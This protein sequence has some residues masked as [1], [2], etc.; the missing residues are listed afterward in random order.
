MKNKLLFILTLIFISSLLCFTISGC[1]DSNNNVD[2]RNQEIV[3]IYNTY[4]AHA[5]AIGDTP[6]SYEDWLASIKGEKGDKGDTGAQGPQGEK[7]DAPTMEVSSDGYWIINGIKTEYKAIGIDGEKGDTGVGVKS[8]EYDKQG[9]LIVTLTDNTVLPPVEMPKIHVYGDWIS[10]TTDDFPCEDRIF[11]R[12]CEDCNNIEWKHGTYENHKFNVVTTNPTCQEKGYDEKTC[13]IC[14]KYEK[15]NFTN[16]VDHNWQ[17][18]YTTDNSFHWVK[19]NDCDEIKDKHEHTSDDYNIC[20][21]CV[22]MIGSTEGIIY[23]HKDNSIGVVGYEGTATK[24]I[25]AKEIDGKPVTFIDDYSFA[26]STKS[27]TSVFIP[28]NVT[29]IGALAFSDCTSLKSV[30]FEENSKLENIEFGIFQGCISLET[31]VLPNSV[32]N[33]EDGLFNGCSSLKFVGLPN[34]LEK[35]GSYMFTDCNSLTNIEVP[36]AITS[37]GDW[38][39]YGSSLEYIVIPNTVKHIGE[40]AFTCCNLKYLKFNGTIAEWNSISMGDKSE[41]IKVICSDGEILS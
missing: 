31:I 7:G 27:I 30:I 33:V 2:N 12:V 21:V 39:F 11:Y 8:V 36:N 35:I 22:A 20:T 28:S 16:T 18:K 15:C 3:S 34:S 37:I 29:S 25:I 32:K 24:I 1:K 26:F 10:F 17:D 38:A 41:T 19:C 14:G 5:E 4:V 13:T 9:R 23:G 6:L 40:E